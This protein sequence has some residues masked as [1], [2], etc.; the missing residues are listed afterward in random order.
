VVVSRE[1]TQKLPNPVIDAA[2]RADAAALPAFAG[3]SLGAQ[4]YVV[5]KVNKVVPREAPLEAAARQERGQ[6]A[7]WWTAAENLAYYNGLKER[8]KTKILVAKPPV[9]KANG[10]EV[11]TQ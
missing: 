8:F 10:E 11:V 6:Y 5:I 2:L 3:V 7:Q 1:Q 9:A 4:G